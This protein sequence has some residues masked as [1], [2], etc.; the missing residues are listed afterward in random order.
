MKTI[1]SDEFT[2]EVEKSNLPVLVD[3]FTPLCGPCK[4]IAP[5]LEEIAEERHGTLKVVKVDASIEST[6]A[7]SLRIQAVPTVFIFRH[8]KPV[9]QFIGFRAKKELDK[10]IDEAIAA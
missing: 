5:L 7:A 1:T 9:A 3:F 8:G 10:W 2:T 6:L 4:Q